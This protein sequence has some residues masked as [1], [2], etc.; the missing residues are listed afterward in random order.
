MKWPW[1][2]EALLMVSTSRTNNVSEKHLSSNSCASLIP[3]DSL[4]SLLLQV[5]LLLFFKYCFKSVS[6]SLEI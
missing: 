3:G 6:S 2:S 4:N 5:S 1:R